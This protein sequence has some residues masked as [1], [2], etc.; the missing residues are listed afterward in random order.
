VDPKRSPR[1]SM[2]AWSP[3]PAARRP[4]APAAM[5]P[6]AATAAAAKGGPA[7]SESIDRLAADVQHLR[8]DFERFFSGV[9]PVPP[10]ELRRRVQVQ[11]RQLRNVNA[12][13]AVDRFRLGDLEARYNSYNELFSRRLRDLEEGRQRSVHAPPPAPADSPRYDPAAG[14]VIGREPEPAAVAALYE[15][16]FAEGG[17]ASGDAGASA[18]SAAHAPPAAP[19]ARRP[20][21]DLASFGSYLQRQA[22]AI[23]DQTGCAEV[24]FRL[25]AEDGKWKLKARPVGGARSPAHE[26]KETT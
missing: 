10:E 15:G 17:G 18:A 16:L 20:R 4:D 24:Q 21:F 2:G 5:A 9:L 26:T 7:F 25:V 23:R 8:V 22:A 14:I 6:T 12:G 3:S 13:T 1:G 11:L 19:A